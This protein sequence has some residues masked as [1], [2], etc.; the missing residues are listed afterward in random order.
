M[1]MYL[2]NQLYV[3]LIYK[4]KGIAVVRLTLHGKKWSKVITRG[5]YANFGNLFFSIQAY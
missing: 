4:P 3:K 1:R 2:P 5:I